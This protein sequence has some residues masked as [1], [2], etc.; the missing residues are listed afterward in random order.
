MDAW[1]W[2]AI[3]GIVAGTAVFAAL[4]VPLLVWQSQRFGRLTI[5]RT[6]VAGAA[7]IYG[8]TIL[9]YTLL[10]FRD[11]AWCRTHTSP[12]P[13]FE[14]FRS[15]DD[16]AAAVSGLSLGQALRSAVVLQVLMNVV[17][18]VP[19][20][21]FSRRLLGRPFLVGVASAFAV[22]V[23]IETIQGTGWFGL[24]PCVY[25]MAEVDDVI[26]NTLGAA[27]GV[28]IAPLLLWW[29][30]DPQVDIDQR[31]TPRP[32][33]RA[34]RL[35]GMVVDWSAFVAVWAALTIAVRVVDRL[36]LATPLEAHRSWT[37][38]VGPG[39]VAA[40]VVGLLPLLLGSGASLGQR[41]VWLAP[42]R[43]RKARSRGV[44]R[45]ATGLGAYATLSISEAIP[46]SSATTR[47]VLSAV[48]WAIL[49]LSALAVLVDPR[50]RGISF[51]ASGSGLVDAREGPEAADMA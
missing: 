2:S 16:I 22:S 34:R 3:T 47:S 25:R 27:V 30:P 31:R 35:I 50:A 36:E 6:V 39:I 10:P 33:T 21:A 13:S 43:G 18:F 51:L 14:P 46:G 8:V 48:G 37:D 24:A 17:L 1:R 4:F 5:G 45:F 42:A 12:S 44:L 19:W 20:G 49:G 28:V 40:V 15:L 38:Q 41:A 7:A 32:V 9:T 29:I 11:D 26:T 23:S